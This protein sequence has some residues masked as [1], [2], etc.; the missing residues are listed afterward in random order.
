[1]DNRVI[2]WRRLDLDGVERLSIVERDEQVHIAGTVI[3]TEDGGFQIDHLW[4]LDADW[5]AQAVTVSRSG[6][7]GAK[8]VHLE[9]SGED[10]LVDGIVRADLIGAEEPDLSV[11]PFCNTLPVRRLLKGSSDT[12]T[13]DIVYIDGATLEVTRSRQAYDQIAAGRVRYRDLGLFAGFEA[14]LDVDRDGIVCRYEGLFEQVAIE[15]AAGNG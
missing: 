2:F 3:A 12:I 11:T 7:G 6:A 8:A 9:R 15:P 4:S 5:S 14:M 10:W 1:M 13:L